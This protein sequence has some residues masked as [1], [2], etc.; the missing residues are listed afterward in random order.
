[1]SQVLRKRSFILLLSLLSSCGPGPKLSPQGDL[2][3]TSPPGRPTQ[4]RVNGVPCPGAL[5]PNSV[6]QVPS[7]SGAVLI[8]GYVDDATSVVTSSD[9]S[10]LFTDLDLSDRRFE[11]STNVNHGESRSLLFYSQNSSGQRSDPNSLVLSR[12]ALLAS[13]ILYSPS[14][15]GIASDQ[16]SSGVALK[17]FGVGSLGVQEQLSAGGLKLDLGF[18][19]LLGRVNP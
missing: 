1:M 14:L 17:S 7:G 8:D 13:A 11:F 10:G 9:S 4:L 19:N 6:F 16:S 3:S 12:P 18:S 15:L 5:C 2:T